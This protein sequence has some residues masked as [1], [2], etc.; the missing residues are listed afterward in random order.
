[1][2][3]T[4]NTTL[5]IT[6]SGAV[7][8]QASVITNWTDY[9]PPRHP[10]PGGCVSATSN[11]AHITVVPNPLTSGARK[12]ESIL[13]RYLDAA[14]RTVTIKRNDDGTKTE[15]YKCQIGPD[16]VVEYDGRTWTCGSASGQQAGGG[17][18]MTAAQVKT[19]Y[20][21]NPDTNAYTNAEKTKLAGIKE[22]LAVTD[23]GGLQAELDAKEPANA[24][25][26]GHI[27]SAHAPAGATVNSPDAVLLNRAN[28]TGTQAAA[29]ISDFNAAVAANSAV[30][31]NTAKVT[32]Q[33]HTGDVTGSTALTIAANAVSNA[34]LATMAT[35]T[36][37]GRTSAGTGNAEDVSVAALKADLALVKGDV[38]L[39]NVDNTADVNKPVSTAVQSALNGKVSGTVRVTV[40]A[41]APTSP[42]TN[43]M[44]I[45]TN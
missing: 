19:L 21:S 24:N 38:G 30:A 45:D 17:E 9:Q 43:D 34:K 37:K 36:Y 42:A 11:T 27:A 10:S 8:D 4:P 14:T 33:T 13:V 18:S 20:E 31:A 29:T 7:T 16:T 3:L 5:E 6:L 22:S 2:H 23:V 35:K 28:H 32:N 40:S 15:V 26:Q 25:I 1:M 41:T 12:V 44:W 39:A